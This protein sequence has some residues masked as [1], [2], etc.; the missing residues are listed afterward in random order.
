MQRENPLV[1]YPRFAW[2]TLRKL[3]GYWGVYRRFKKILDEALAAPDRWTY[4]DVAIAA[5]RQD[6]FE[7]MALYHE[8][9][10]GE[11]ALA[12]KRR[13]D[14]IRATGHAPELAAA[15]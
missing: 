12:R 8:T 9:A 4:S 7:A 3:R 5:P 10:G 11:A 2:E 15:K 13:D 14:S 1:F 6:E